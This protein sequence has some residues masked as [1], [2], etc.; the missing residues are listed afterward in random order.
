MSKSPH[1]PKLTEAERH[2][3]FVDMAKEVG[4]SEKKEDFDAALKAVLASKPQP[5]SKD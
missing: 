2:K 4:A 3:R 1:K 5:R